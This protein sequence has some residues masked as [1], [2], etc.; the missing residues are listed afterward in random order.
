MLSV[1][2][3]HTLHG[4]V[5]GLADFAREDQPPMLPLL[6]YAFR[7]MAGVGFLFV[8]LAL[9]TAWCLRR[10]RGRLDALLERRW[11]LRAWVAA[12]PL[13]YIAVEAGWIVREVG[14]QPWVVYGLLRTR[15]AV[16]AV[17]PG[18]VA[19]STVM[20]LSFYLVLIVTFF[21][22]ARRWLRTGPDLLIAPAR[23]AAQAADSYTKVG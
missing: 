1:L 9:W 11:L 20:F 21:L 14:R 7:V 4:T 8:A 12:T 18:H 22:L 5:K 6:Y 13:P 23:A 15:D 16:S 10:V 2:G 19:A 3:T 17:P